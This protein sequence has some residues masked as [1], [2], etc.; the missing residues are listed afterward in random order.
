LPPPPL[1]PFPTRRSSDLSAD[2]ILR[3][4]G[5]ANG[6]VACL[7]LQR[8]D[9]RLHKVELANRTDVLAECRA[10]KQAVDQK[11]SREVGDDDPRCPRSEEHT[12]E[13]QSR[14]HLVC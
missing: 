9:E 10:A 1:P 2:A 4:A 3:L 13:L 5:G 7:D 11:R 8:R 14:G 6:R 12:S